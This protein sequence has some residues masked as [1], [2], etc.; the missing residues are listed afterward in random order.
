MTIVHKS[1]SIEKLFVEIFENILEFSKDIPVLSGKCIHNGYNE[2]FSAPVQTV[3]GPTKPHAQ[4]LPGLF[5]GGKVAARGVALNT[6]P[7]SAEVKGRVQLYL[8][9]P[10]VPAWPVLR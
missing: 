4:W 6:P 8:Y 7:S 2:H 10:S 1:V 9:S 5:P 3:T